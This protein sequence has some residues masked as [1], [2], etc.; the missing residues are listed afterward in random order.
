MFTKLADGQ[1]DENKGQ[2]APVNEKNK[3]IRLF[4]PRRTK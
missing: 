3:P 4:W 2:R 1:I